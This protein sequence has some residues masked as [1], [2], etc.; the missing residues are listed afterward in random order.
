MNS[1]WRNVREWI[2]RF[3]LFRDQSFLTK[4]FLF[5]SFLVIIS[6]LSVG[7]I[8]YLRSSLELEEEVKGSSL[9]VIEQVETHI[10]Y[11]IRDFEITS[12]RIINS[13]Q[14]IDYLKLN[15]I[16][17][18]SDGEIRK[19]V[20]AILKDAE[21][22]RSDI[23]NITV[24]LDNNAE[25]IDTLGDRNYYPASKIRQEYWYSSI[26]QNGLSLLVS[27]TLKLSNKEEPVISLVRRLYNPETL[28]PVGLLLIDI[29][30]RRIEE[31]SN[32]V[33]LSKNGVFF[34]LDSKGHYVY[35]PNHLK[36]GQEADFSQI[37]RFSSQSSGSMILEQQGKHFITYT[38]SP[39]LGWRFFTAIPYGQLMR[40]TIQIG[41][42]IAWTILVSLILAY[43]L[44]Y[45]FARSLIGPIKRLQQYM[46]EI[47]VGNLQARVQVESHDEIGQLTL[48][49]NR[50]VERLSSL[51][52]EVYFAKLRE[53][54]MSLRQKNVE[55]KML[56]SQINPHF[57][58]NS[59]ETI[60]GMA[61]EEE[62]E[63]IATMAF[64][65]GK[66]L[67]FNLR[68][69]LPTVSLGEEQKFAEMYLQI[70]KFRFEHRFD[71]QFDIPEWALSYKVVKFSLQPLLENC[72]VHGFAS[73]VPKLKIN[74][75]V[76][77]ESKHSFVVEITD[78]GAGISA[79]I[80]Q[81]IEANLRQMEPKI[82]ESNIGIANVHKRIV[83]LFGAEFGIRV[84]SQ[85]GAGT[86]VSIRMPIVKDGMG[87]EH[88]EQHFAG[89]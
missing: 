2:Q 3:V 41:Q 20:K 25:V 23:S 65:L 60:R 32:K 53:T 5:S 38:Y 71:Y 35:H 1:R 36:L 70:Q 74:I 55:L 17:E 59:L 85:R 49:F 18:D 33:S 69:N 40:G 16:E 34:I 84:R 43:L 62:Q 66:L 72:F 78:N 80:L 30:F 61:L 28:Q 24:I 48:G 82:G 56:Q 75:S 31:I 46:R 87:E 51:L 11:Y 81:E 89:G 21:Y 83:N 68:N 64:L 73:N 54:E 88:N 15:S 22:S 44:G 10:E 57:L 7:V 63:S 19:S 29:N 47:E 26:P 50:M 58:Y 13:P 12:L 45:G 76:Y 39:S 77:R 42:T 4:L 9:Q 6:M 8:S 14:L 67:R 86:T 52:E 79:E 27:R 37:S